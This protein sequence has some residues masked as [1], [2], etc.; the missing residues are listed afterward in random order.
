MRG[1]KK[2]ER[3]AEEKQREKQREKRQHTGWIHFEQQEWGDYVRQKD[4]HD[5]QDDVQRDDHL[6]ASERFST[7]KGFGR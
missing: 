1:R 3:E 7:G 6:S 2:G 4:H 5:E